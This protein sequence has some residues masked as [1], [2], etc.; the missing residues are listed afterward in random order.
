MFAL[1]L[2]D[3]RD[4]PIATAPRAIEGLEIEAPG[5]VYAYD[6]VKGVNDVGNLAF[7]PLAQVDS[8]LR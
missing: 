1:R 2:A 7:V 4:A 5:V 3:G 6:T 8:L